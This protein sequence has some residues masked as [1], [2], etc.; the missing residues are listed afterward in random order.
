MTHSHDTHQ[1]DRNMRSAL[2]GAEVATIA[3]LIFTVLLLAAAAA[4]DLGS[5]FM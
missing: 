4:A 3:L 1:R 5:W 2:T